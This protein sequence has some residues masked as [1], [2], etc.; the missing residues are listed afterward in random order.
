M[1]LDND[2]ASQILIK[3]TAMEGQL[4]R[5]VSDYESEKETRRR[6]NEKVDDRIKVL[7]D[8]KNEIHGRI[9]VTVAIA[10]LL[11]AAVIAVI[12]KLIK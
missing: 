7:E 12:V 6:K 9:V 5:L 4:E 10:G 1:A 2:K 3:I 8:W 11:W